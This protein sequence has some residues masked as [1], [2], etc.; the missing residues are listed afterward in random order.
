MVGLTPAERGRQFLQQVRAD[1]AEVNA[2]LTRE[3]LGRLRQ[4]R[5]QLA[6]PAAFRDPEVA[7]ALELTPEQRD[8]IRAI[9][10]EWLFAWTKKMRDGSGP[11]SLG[12]PTE[13]TG[14][15]THERI[16]E[17]LTE[18]QSRRWKSMI[19]EPFQG[20]LIPFPL[21]HGPPPKS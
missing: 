19:G 12:Q 18:E 20:L 21:P 10:E 16:L 9:E 8:R 11:G 4:I 3:Q 13:P 1:E 6:G 5:L 15:P 17:L 2:I 7:A 14:R